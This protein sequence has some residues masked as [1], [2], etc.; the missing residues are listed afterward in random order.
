MILAQMRLQNKFSTCV[1][2]NK[3]YQERVVF[4]L[5][6][7]VANELVV[8][9]NWSHHISIINLVCSAN[10]VEWAITSSML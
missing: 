2:N 4:S 6:R 10:E 1:N 5:N 7:A 9:E 3:G 8:I